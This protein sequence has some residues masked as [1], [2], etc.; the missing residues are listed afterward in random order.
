MLKTEFLQEKQLAQKKGER[1]YRRFTKKI[2]G[3]GKETLV[4]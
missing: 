4:S 2:E 3:F 1:G